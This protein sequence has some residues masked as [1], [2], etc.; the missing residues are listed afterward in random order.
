VDFS[1]ARVGF[2]AGFLAGMG[3]LGMVIPGVIA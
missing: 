2:A 3:M 1:V